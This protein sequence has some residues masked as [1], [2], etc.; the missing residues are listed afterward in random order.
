[1]ACE[2]KICESRP[3]LDL[4]GFGYAYTGQVQTVLGG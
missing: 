2:R 3:I 1:M 4:E